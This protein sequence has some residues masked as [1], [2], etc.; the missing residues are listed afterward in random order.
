MATQNWKQFIIMTKL[1]IGNAARIL[2][3]DATRL[4]RVLIWRNERYIISEHAPVDFFNQSQVLKFGSKRQFFSWSTNGSNWYSKFNIFRTQAWGKSTNTRLSSFRS[5]YRIQKGMPKGLYKN[6]N[7]SLDP[8]FVGQKMYSTAS[9]RFT[10]EAANNITIPLRCFFSSWDDKQLRK[11]RKNNP[12]YMIP[13]VSSYKILSSQEINLFRDYQ[14]MNM[15]KGQ[16]TSYSYP[17]KESVGSYV[18]FKFL[19]VDPEI[20]LPDLCFATDDVLHKW[21]RSLELQSKR[22]QEIENCVMQIISTYGNLPLSFTKD[23]VKVYFLNRSTV[24]TELLLIDLGI[25]I[26]LVNAEEVLTET[27]SDVDLENSLISTSSSFLT[28]EPQRCIFLPI[29]S[30]ELETESSGYLSV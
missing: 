8:N 21:R 16:K 29:L 17:C 6:W 20:Q 1:Q 5:S 30:E 7:I 4:L 25:E 2:K 11:V 18:E 19:E 26:G 12:S 27:L 28:I 13:S 3:N 10:H 9:V 14:I 23:S 15:I 22:L 24:E